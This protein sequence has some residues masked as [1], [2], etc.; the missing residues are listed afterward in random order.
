MSRPSNCPGSPHV[1]HASSDWTCPYERGADDPNLRLIDLP[2]PMDTG[3][4]VLVS[5][6]GTLSLLQRK[7]D[8]LW[9]W[10]NALTGRVNWA[11]VINTSDVITVLEPG[12][13]AYRMEKR[14]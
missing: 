9:G 2:E 1:G 13:R 6:L 8:G 12:A 10:L 7:A 4:L 3:S 11:F 14:P 5:S